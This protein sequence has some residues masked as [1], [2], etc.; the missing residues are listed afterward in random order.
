[1]SESN[2]SGR[3]TISGP[4]RIDESV[5]RLVARLEPGEIAVIEVADLD[6]SSALSLL[7]GRPAAVLNAAPSTTGRK[8]SLGASLLVEGGVP[9]VDDL[10][11]DV[12]TLSEGQRIRLVESSVY[13][14]ETLVA[15]GTRR[16]PE[17]LRKEVTA[18]RARLRP[19]VESFAHSVTPVWEQES[20]LYLDGAGLPSVPNLTGRTVIVVGDGLD[21]EKQLRSLKRFSRDFSAYLIASGSTTKL[22]GR[23]LRTPDMIVGDIST[24]PERMLREGRPLFLLE[25]PDGRVPG[26]ERATTLGLD[27]RLVS[28]VASE[29]SVAVLLANRLQASQIVTIGDAAGL[30]G[31]LEQ[32]AASAAAEFFIETEARQKLV[33]ALSAKTMYRP[34]IGSIQ[35]VF[36]LLAALAALVVAVLFTPAG[37][38][39][40][41]NLWQWI[42]NLWPGEAGA[43]AS[44]LVPPGYFGY[45]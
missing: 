23:I 14:G 28:T 19:H 39:L 30:D 40:G 20:P 38:G 44:A 34:G 15:E 12:M 4:V 6:R 10:G 16:A 29:Q 27:Y 22:V 36:L 37:G 32:P 45:L 8:A 35:L 21:V 43:D 13:L 3:P 7:A 1:M 17:E 25:G 24:T 26:S 31:F 11:P 2:G 18:G 41:M 9:V 33:S 42:V 5:A